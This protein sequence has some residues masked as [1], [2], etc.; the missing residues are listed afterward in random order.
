MPSMNIAT[1]KLLTRN[2][3]RFESKQVVKDKS[4][5]PEHAKMVISLSMDISA[6]GYSYWVYILVQAS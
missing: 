6:V 2:W 3:L 4:E 1:S 5:S